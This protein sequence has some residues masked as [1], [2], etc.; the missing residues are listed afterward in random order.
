V[1]GRAAA[2]HQVGLVRGEQFPEPLAAAHL[3]AEVDGG[4][5]GEERGEHGGEQVFPGG[6]RRG[7]PDPA[8]LG[9]AVA[10]GGGQPL[11]V[12]AEDGPGVAGIGLAGG[13]QPQ[14][15]AVPFDQRHPHLA[16][17]RGQRRGHRGLGDG[18]ASGR[19]SHR[20]RVRHGHQRPQPRHRRHDTPKP[21]IK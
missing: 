6:G 4:V 1:A 10:A 13:G 5:V 11:L 3:Q 15:A 16:G 18:Q 19:L 7:D 21:S 12:Q 9:V 17:Q 8:A 14:A 2:D 20:T